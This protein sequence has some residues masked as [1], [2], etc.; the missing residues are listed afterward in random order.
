MNP[1]L[2]VFRKQSQIEA[3]HGNPNPSGGTFIHEATIRTEVQNAFWRAENDVTNRNY[4]KRRKVQFFDG[5]LVH[6]NTRENIFDPNRKREKK[7]SEKKK[8]Q[9]VL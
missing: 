2:G 9:S 3:D 8:M 6:F 1:T 5:S 4:L 7:T